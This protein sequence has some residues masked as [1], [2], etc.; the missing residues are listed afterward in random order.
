MPVS[1]TAPEIE[2][3]GLGVSGTGE[4]PK[5]EVKQASEYFHRL[6]REP[7]AGDFPCR[8]PEAREAGI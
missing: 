3:L 2:R 6:W 7:R 1:C 4:R 5:V 8:T